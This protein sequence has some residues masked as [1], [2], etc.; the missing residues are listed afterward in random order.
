MSESSI[1]KK[2]LLA[3]RLF[4]VIFFGVGVA[5]FTFGATRELFQQL[6]PLNLIVSTVLLFCFHENWS[7]KHV[8][9]FTALAVAGFLVEMAGIHTGLVFGSYSYGSALGL[10]LFSTPA[11][12]GVNWLVLIYAIYVLFPAIN[13]RWFYPFL[14]SAFLVVY[15]VVMEP[16]AMATD[17]WNWEGGS[18]PMKNYITWYM[19]SVVMLYSLR[20]FGIH[21]RN[22][23]AQ[24]LLAI[25]FIFFLILNF[26]LI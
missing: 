25:Q 2:Y 5:G 4:L 18:V 15:D 11:L 8:L 22:R 1:E 7:L 26:L 21:Y 17:M 3:A 16:V 23:V 24:W 10:K 20:F 13:Q 6:V 14:G 9:V 19:V 12:I